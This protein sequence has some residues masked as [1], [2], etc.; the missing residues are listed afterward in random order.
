MPFVSEPH[1]DVVVGK[2]PEFLDEAVG[3]FLG[4]FARQERDDLIAAAQ[5]LRPVSPVAVWS[6][7]E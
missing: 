6:V 4:P 7:D 3:E 1:G 5:E 2:G